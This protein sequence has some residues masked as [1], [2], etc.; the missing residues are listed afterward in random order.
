[1]TIKEYLAAPD[2]T[3][4]PNPC[5]PS[6][7]MW[8]RSHPKKCATCL[9][10]YYSYVPVGEFWPPYLVDP[11]PAPGTGMR[12]TCGDPWCYEQE[13]RHQDR[14]DPR[15]QRASEAYETLHPRHD[16]GETAQPILK[17]PM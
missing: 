8:T 6:G 11:D 9:A 14:R 3:E 7:R 13:A 4:R 12:G 17:K 15:V 10:F 1:M 2:M 5:D 16:H